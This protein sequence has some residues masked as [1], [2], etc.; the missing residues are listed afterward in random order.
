MAW[1][2]WDPLEEVIVGG[3]KARRSHRPRHRDLQPAAGRAA[4]LS[5]RAGFEVPEVHEEARAERA[6]RLHRRSSKARASGP[7][8]RH[9]R[10]L[11]QVTRRRAGPRAASASPARATATSSSATRSSRARCAGARATSRATPTA[12]C[13]RNISGNGAR[14]TS[15]PRPQLTDDLYDYDYR[16]RPEAG[17]PMRYTV[18]EFEPVF[19]AADFVRCGRDLFVTRS[20]VT[21]L[22][23]IEWLRR[24]LGPGFRIHEIESRCPQ[25]MHIDSSFMPLAP[26]KVL[27]NPDYVR[28]RAPACV[29][30]TMGRADRAPSRS[31]LG[32]H[33]QDLDVLALDQ[34]QRPDAGREEGRRRR[35]QPTLIKAL[36]DWGFDPIPTPV[37]VLRA[38]RRLL[39]LRDPRRAPP[40]HPEVLLLSLA[41]ASAVAPRSQRPSNRQCGNDK[42]A[43]GLNRT[44]IQGSLTNSAVPKPHL[45]SRS[46]VCVSVIR[47]CRR[48]PTIAAPAFRGVRPSRTRLGLRAGLS[49]ALGGAPAQAADLLAA[50]PLPAASPPASDLYIVTVS[51]NLQGVPRFPGSDRLT[52]LGYPSIGFRRVDEPERFS[53]P[54]DGLSFSVLETPSLRLGAVARYESGRY[55]ADDRKN[56]FGLRDVKWS[57]EPAR[58]SRFGRSSGCAPAPR[59]ATASTATTASSATSDSMGCSS[60][61]ASPFRSARGSPSA[62]PISPALTSASRPSRRPSTDGSRRSG[63][64]AA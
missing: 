38:V 35:I 43:I 14:W 42:R 27:V 11:A 3:L 31:R 1:N 32:L 10:F 6:R 61:A 39:P 2:E 58:S 24:H 59:S 18:N 13:S 40:R 64:E 41:G 26:G 52:F 29:L 22:M 20:N 46:P 44:R 54:D 56:L 9:H 16:R 50:Q 48:V 55:F 28:R 15:A 36:K 51:A 60:S 25:P 23:G 4:V 49:A 8:A 33:E 7:A 34:H 47:P 19:D 45:H 57:V 21:N 30:K 63:P 17:E 62:A 12:R 53:A 5:L 37:P